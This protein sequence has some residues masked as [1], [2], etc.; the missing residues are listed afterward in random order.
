MGSDNSEAEEIVPYYLVNKVL[1][2]FLKAGSKVTYRVL[3]STIKRTFLDVEITESKKLLWKRFPSAD[4]NET[5]VDKEKWIDQ[6]KLELQIE[7]IYKRLAYLGNND[8][9]PQDCVCL[10]WSEV[11]SLPEYLSDE[12]FELQIE[13]KVD[14]DML[15]ERMDKIEKQNSDIVKMLT[16]M[17]N[18]C[19]DKNVLTIPPPRVADLRNVDTDQPMSPTKRR[20]YQEAFP[21]IACTSQQVTTGHQT[22]EINYLHPNSRQDRAR[23]AAVVGKDGGNDNPA[24][25]RDRSNSRLRAVSGTFN[26]SGDQGVRKMKVAPVDIFV[27]G[28]HKDTSYEDIVEELKYSDIDIDKEDIEEKTRE[29]SNVKSYKISIKAEFLEKALKPETWPL[30]VKVREWVY[31]PRKRSPAEGG[32]MG[33]R[34]AT[35]GTQDKALNSSLYKHTTPEGTAASGEASKQD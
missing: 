30:R 7:D 2:V 10:P 8:L 6:H 9:L 27:Y 23:Y 14:S 34:S 35:P 33:Q 22:G 5:K 25:S 3:E 28:V 24:R 32:K 17:K 12:A 31:F 21:E 16:E 20:K 26:G 11:D 18:N 13:K 4:P 1:T 19:M 15:C 29:G